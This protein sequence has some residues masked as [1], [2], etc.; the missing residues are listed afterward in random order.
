MGAR[1]AL[2]IVNGSQGHFRYTDANGNPIGLTIASEQP[3]YVQGNYNA[4]NN[5]ATN[6]GGYTHLSSAVVADAVTLLS[7]AFD[8]RYSLRISEHRSCP[9]RETQRQPTSVWRSRPGKTSHSSCRV[10]GGLPTATPA[11]MAAFTTSSAILRTGS[12]R[13]SHYRGSL[14]S[15]YY[16]RYGNGIYGNSYVYSPP[17]RDYSFDTDFLNPNLLPPGTPKLIDM[18]N[19]SA[20]QDMS[21]RTY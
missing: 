2:K 14:V 21:P 10:T 18:D 1:H 12:G 4:D 5:D 13:T 3:V 20:H 9:D 7:N 8:D 15:M 6:W 19:L 16:A 11:R 17:T